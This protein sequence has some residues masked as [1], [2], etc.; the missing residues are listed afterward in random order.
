MSTGCNCPLTKYHPNHFAMSRFLAMS[1]LGVTCANNVLSQLPMSMVESRV[2]SACEPGHVVS[3]FMKQWRIGVFR[4]SVVL[5]GDTSH[6]PASTG[7]DGCIRMKVVSAE[8]I[9][10][11]N[12]GINGW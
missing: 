12:Y 1:A 6:C 8:S 5:V 3:D 2:A 10:S 11:D 4:D 9:C 7:R